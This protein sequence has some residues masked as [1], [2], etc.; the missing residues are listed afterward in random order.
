MSTE[1]NHEPVH[2]PK[3]SHRTCN[4]VDRNNGI[5]N[6]TGQ[7]VGDNNFYSS[8][9]QKDDLALLRAE[10]DANL[11]LMAGHLTLPTASGAMEVERELFRDL[12]SARGSFLLTGDP[13]IGKT[14]LIRKLAQHYRDRG[15]DVVLLDA[16]TYPERVGGRLVRNLETVLADWEGDRPSHLFI[17]ALDGDRA[18]MAEQLARTVELLEDTRWRTVASARL[19]D[20][21]HNRRWRKVFSGAPVTGEALYRVTDL[22]EVRHFRVVRLTESEL[23]QAGAGVPGLA[24]VLIGVGSGLLSNPFNLYLACELLKLDAWP[25]DW[26]GHL[27]Q[28]VLLERYWGH[29]A[30][31]E[32]RPGRMRLL[33]ELCEVMLKR[34]RLQVGQGFLSP[35]NDEAVRALTGNGV[36]QEMTSGYAYAMPSLAF[37]H[38]ILFDY[39]VSRMIFVEEG[40]SKLEEWLDKLPNLVFVARPGI[41]LHLFETWHTDPTRESFAEVCRSLAATEHV[42]AGVATAT[43]MVDSAR[44]PKDV[45]WLSTALFQGD[46]SA[47]EEIVGQVIGVLRG[48]E[49]RDAGVRKTAVRIWA[50]VATALAQRLESTFRRQTVDLLYRLLRRLQELDPLGPDAES[51]SERA[52]CVAV[53]MSC[54]LEDTTGRAGIAAAAATQLPAAI[55]VDGG[56]A[57]LLRRIIYD[58][59]TRR[60]NSDV[61]LWSV[62]GAVDI[63][64]GAPETAA[65]L[66]KTVWDLVGDRHEPTVMVRGVVPLT[67]NL[68]QDFEGVRFQVGGV[69]PDVL[70]LIGVEE[71]CRLLAHATNKEYYQEAAD[72]GRYPLHFQGETG[73]VICSLA[74]LGHDAPTK[75]LA[76]LL[77]WAEQTGVDGVMITLRHLVRYVWHPGAWTS[78]MDRLRDGGLAWHAMSVEL[79]TSGA[80]LANP[81]TRRSA[82]DLLGVL[83]PEVEAEGHHRLEDA[84]L[85]AAGISSSD[86]QHPDMRVI[87][88]LVSYL[89]TER[90]TCQPLIERLR[91][92]ERLAEPPEVFFGGIVSGFSAI[93]ARER[94]GETASAELGEARLSLLDRMGDLSVRLRQG[95]DPQEREGLGAL[96]MEVVHE[97]MLLDR[98]G[99]DAQDAVAATIVSV[100]ERLAGFRYTTP[101]SELGRQVYRVL[102]LAIGQE[103]SEKGEGE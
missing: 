2:A 26:D 10:T 46:E 96:F 94:F 11:T 40:C 67:S 66:L 83:S 51:A 97:P 58:E 8:D 85:A 60:R 30:V 7:H 15:D 31:E 87:D 100:A 92:V 33:R 55:T 76:A 49:E 53:M 86:T 16:S 78:V 24:Q 102:L 95:S 77:D 27:D 59:P 28:S 57:E 25:N 91:E 39:A 17:D 61:F 103:P 6:Q 64:R 52:G 42:L 34:R 19:Y 81:V 84:V 68:A 65:E 20:I 44:T 70:P 63:A 5:V 47:A 98:V 18:G 35:G 9:P 79:L 29:R 89:D 12:V 21:S 1:E 32:D 14:A 69:F 72:R 45:G 38:H 22:Q 3:T 13:G 101:G 88:E 74:T 23:A 90:L 41:D 93:T 71:A 82:A 56:H 75:M 73:Q 43:V 99:P 4:R 36:L 62:R 54:A 50:T 48:L 37:S 80:L